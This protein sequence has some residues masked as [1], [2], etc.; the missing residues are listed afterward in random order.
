MCSWEE[1]GRT[2]TDDGR[3]VREDLPE[4]IT[5]DWVFE[6]PSEV[7]EA[8]IEGGADDKVSL[9]KEIVYTN[10]WKLEFV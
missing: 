2:Y 7:G 9:E 5:L 3:K 10:V 4:K 6:R 1:T 8:E